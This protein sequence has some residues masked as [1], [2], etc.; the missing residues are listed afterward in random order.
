[1]KK[2]K[3]ASIGICFTVLLFSVLAF[4]SPTDKNNQSAEQLEDRFT[5]WDLLMNSLNSNTVG[6]TDTVDLALVMSTPSAAACPNAEITFN[7]EVINQGQTLVESFELTNYIPAGLTLSV[8]NVGWV[9][10]GNKAKKTITGPLP[11][12]GISSQTILFV[13]D[14]TFSDAFLENRAEISAADCDADPN[15][16]APFELDST[17]DDIDNDSIGGDN[18][19]DNSFGDEDDHDFALVL[20]DAPQLTDT[21]ITN[22]LCNFDNGTISLMPTSFVG[23]D[24]SDGGTGAMRTGLF[25]GIYE[26]TITKSNGCTNV[27]SNLE[28]NNDCT[29]CEP[30]AGTV[31]PAANTFCMTADSVIVDFTDDGNSFEPQPQFITSYILT[32]GDSKAVLAIDTTK[33]FVIR[34]TGTYRIHVKVLDVLH[35]NQEEVDSVEVG[36]TPLSF[37]N[38]FLAQGG[39][40]TCGALD[41]TGIVFVVGTATTT[42]DSISNEACDMNDGYVLLSPDTYTYEWNDGATSHERNDLTKGTYSVTVTGSAGCLDTIQ[43]III[44][45]NCILNDTIPFIIET[46]STETICFDGLPNY[47]SNNTIT[48]LCAGGTS[49]TDGTLGN[50]SV[51]ETGCLVYVAGNMAQPN[52]D[53]ICVVVN[54]D[55]GNADT[56]VFIPTIIC[57]TVP[58]IVNV[59]CDTATSSG[60][61]CLDIPFDSLNNYNITLNNVPVQNGFIGCA[62]DSLIVYDYNNLFAQ[63]NFGPYVLDSWGID[64]QFF[65]TN[66][67]TMQ[68]LTDSLNAW[69]DATWLLDINTFTISGGDASKVYDNL[70]ITHPFTTSTVNFTPMTNFFFAGTFMLLPEGTHQVIYTESGALCPGAVLQATVSCAACVPYLPADTVQVIAQ[71]CNNPADFCVGIS[72]ADILGYEIIVDGA[73]YGGTFMA[74]DFAGMN[75]GSSLQLSVGLHE[76]IFTEIQTSCA[77]TVLVNVTCT[78]CQDWL[79]DTL[80]TFTTTT[81]S[82]PIFACINVLPAELSDYEIRDNGVIFTGTTSTCTNGTDAAIG[83]D[84]GYH[85]ITM[86]HLITGCMDTTA[87]Q[88]NCVPDTLILTTIFEV[89]G[90]D[91]LCLDETMVGDIAAVDISCGDT[92]N[93]DINITFD[94][95]TNCII[96][97]GVAIGSDTLCFRVFNGMG[98][99]T[100]VTIFVNVTP[101]CG[102]SLFTMDTVYMESSNCFGLTELCLDI[103]LNEITNY[104]ITDNG[105]L[106]EDG[107]AGCDFDTTLS[108]TYF[109]L[110]GQGAAGPYRLD[111]WMVN[112]TMF[113]GEFLTIADLVDSMNTWDASSVWQQDSTTLL[114]EG[115]N[116]ASEYGNM[117]V[118][119]ISTNAFA[120]LEINMNL[121]ANGVALLLDTRM[122]EIVFTDTAT[123]CQDTLFASMVCLRPEVVM[124]TINIGDS[125]T[126]CVDTTELMGNV[127]SIENVCTEESGDLVAFEIVDSSFCVNYVGLAVGDN[128]ACIIVCDDLGLCDTTTIFVN[129]LDTMMISTTLPVVVDDVDTTLINQS[130]VINVAG[131]DTING[132]FDSIDIDLLTP[133]LHGTVT[134]NFDGTVNYTPEEDYCDDNI[135]DAFTYVLCNLAGCD[136]ATVEVWVL[137]QGDEP[138]QFYSGFSPNGDNVNDYFYIQGVESYPNNVLCIFNRWGNRVFYKEGYDNT[139]DNRF[140]GRWEN[141]RLPGGTYFYVFDDGTGNKY[142]GYVQIAK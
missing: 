120:L 5:G 45:S 8:N 90:T 22:S 30:T 78:P 51:S 53:T 63:G 84:T 134:V 83:L 76:V 129:V 122:H 74:C 47:F 128:A 23:Y 141:T 130:T 66:F 111:A 42:I 133:P 27:I 132:P 94:T 7:I 108:Y 33:N 98:D 44:T 25:A 106:Y 28:V 68:E 40:Y 34:D 13:V 62:E 86:L 46:D 71:N 81:C 104:A 140:D 43:N 102:G 36:V 105:S 137:C 103:P 61:I 121:I 37:L 73:N 138:L 75:D 113:S 96:I 79:P 16:A 48:T 19:L 107:F 21:L 139:I 54:D 93:V 91:T 136:T 59:P 49:G 69:D 110:P 82:Q 88:I 39:G 18:I 58:Q 131:N 26:V 100:D 123:L 31:T 57:H 87:V 85:E 126:Y 20:N 3:D 64:G 38:G 1:M 118:T 92:T 99:R 112:D 41:T 15:N 52:A 109:T 17:F 101:P 114:I 10:T 9:Q 119:Q 80:T 50:Y 32:K 12:N 95:L 89:T 116:P 115:G 4:T 65:T 127:V 6:P 77:D 117:T 2:I 24:W 124:D 67:Q 29:G 142:S 135:P 35:I 97:E 56:T 11:M 60:T 14:S 72:T 70:V 55:M 125:V